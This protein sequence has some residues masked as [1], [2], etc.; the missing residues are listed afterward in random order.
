MINLSLKADKVLK[1]KDKGQRRLNFG[2]TDFPGRKP[3]GIYRR[4]LYS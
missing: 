3:A 2:C 1:V 4:S